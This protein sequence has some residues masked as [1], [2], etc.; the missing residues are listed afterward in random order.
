MSVQARDLELA[1]DDLA[2][3]PL[4]WPPWLTAPVVVGGIIVVTWT[5]IAFTVQWW[6]PYDPV[7]TAADTA[8]RLL[9]PS[10]DHLMGTD[11]LGRDV[12]SRMLFG[13][14]QSLPIA[15]IVIAASVSLGCVVGAVAGFFGGW[16]D[17][18]LMRI[19][20]IT[21]SFPPILLAMTVTASLGPGL[22]NAL[23]AMIIVWWPIYARLLRAQ[24]L[25]VRQL[26]HVTAAT[27]MGAGRWR[28]L[29]RHILPLSMTPVLVNATMDFG[30]VV[31]LGAALSFIGLGAVPPNPEWGSM[32]SEGA[33]RFYEWWIAA[34]PGIAIVTVVLGFN[35]LGDGMRDFLDPRTK[36]R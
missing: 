23:F 8:P 9:S 27:A 10:W 12:F 31:L 32:I 11:A 3:R 2:P 5:I 15:A 28:L 20:D 18:L 24:V 4:R 6:A 29:V 14:R 19:S 26:D 13:S 34:A 33:V 35:F 36:R 7:P 21:M 16:L 1:A 22:K 30:Q 25:S 17:A